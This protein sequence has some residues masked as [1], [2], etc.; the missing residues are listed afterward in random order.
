MENKPKLKKLKLSLETIRVLHDAEL[1]M[2]VGAGD[3]DG[4]GD[5][6]AQPPA[7]FCCG[8]FPV[9]APRCN[10]PNPASF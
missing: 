7:T 9:F 2:I 1:N 5:V 3:T 8:S 6:I 4:A 10:I